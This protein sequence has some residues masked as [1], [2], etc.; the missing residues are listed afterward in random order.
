MVVVLAAVF[1][2]AIGSFLNVVIHRVPRRLSLSRPPSQCPRCGNPIRPRHNIPV[3][4]WLLLRGRCADCGEPISARY[5]L[6]EAGTGLLF[7]ALAWRLQQLD[8]LSALPAYAWFAAA[9]VALALIDLDLRKL[10]NAIV[11]PSY[12]VLAVLLT[13]SALVEQEWWPLARA[14]IGAVVLFAFYLLLVLVVPGGMGWGDVKLS[15]LIGGVL[16]YLSWSA[17]VVGAF[18][19]FLLGAVVG[20]VVMA[21]GQGGRKTA[22][23]FGPFMIAAALL[24]VFVADPVARAWN[25]LLSSA[26]T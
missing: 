9:G 6:V 15:G 12:P 1:G 19:G 25:S 22:L 11:L 21:T 17:L 26:G 23:P 4:G 10:P 20:V 5:P 2:L 8:L 3:L 16:A 7:A 13:V 18:G 24:A 14:A